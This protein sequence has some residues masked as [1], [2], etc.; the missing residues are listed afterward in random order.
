MSTIEWKQIP[1]FTRYSAGSD[2]SIRKDTTGRLMSQRIDS[3]G[4]LSCSLTNDDGVQVKKQVHLFVA[5]AFLGAPR[6]GH[7]VCHGAA[8]KSVNTVSNLRHDTPSENAIDK[9]RDGTAL[10][11][12]RHPGNK[13]TEASVVEI[14]RLITERS[15]THKQIG[16]IFAVD[17]ACIGRIAVG[18]TWRH[19][20]RPE[21]M[22]ANRRA[23][24]SRRHQDVKRIDVAIASRF[25][26]SRMA[27][28][29]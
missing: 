20:K 23:L 2:G 22:P 25:V 28:I 11:G 4:Y 18:L 12:S 17:S 14:L 21:N 3:W 9:Y 16:A 15:L 24:T 10:F 6:D 8:G 19:V 26:Q 1:G 13:L 7:V 5:L 29:K 27:A